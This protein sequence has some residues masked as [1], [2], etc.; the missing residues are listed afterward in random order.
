MNNTIIDVAI[1]PLKKK[2]PKENPARTLYAAM[3]RAKS[4]NDLA[5]SVAQQ[6]PSTSNFG[7]STIFNT[8]LMSEPTMNIMRLK[9]S[10]FMANKRVFAKP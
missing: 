2:V 7:I 1:T 8:I 4:K 5:I 3:A 10:L 6:E 9:C